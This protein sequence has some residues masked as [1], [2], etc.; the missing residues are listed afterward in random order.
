MSR[1]SC[2][3]VGVSQLV[4]LFDRA[5]MGFVNHVPGWAVG[6]AAIVFYPILGLIVPFSLKW[7]LTEF[8]YANAVGVC[9]AA[10]LTIG[11]LSAQIEGARRR[12]LV[13]W[14]T[15]L[16]LLDAEE[17]EW[18]VGELYR[19]EGWKV[20]ETGHQDSA[21]GNIDLDL[22]RKGERKIVQCKRWTSWQIGVDEIRSF[23]GTLLR[24]HLPGSAG[25]FV[26]LSEFN[27]HARAEA[28]KM[29]I[30]L[31]DGRD[32]Y[33]RVEKVRRPEPCSS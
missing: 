5:V 10:I 2:H 8:L 12:H 32:L 19:R 14:T 9:V 16:R 31:V 7:S 20:E 13:E 23:G 27:E 26:T 22:K 28:H 25:M 24:E 3:H 30:E 17:F 6:A 1:P 18:L 21:D 4:D 11:W 33:A 15:D 29:H